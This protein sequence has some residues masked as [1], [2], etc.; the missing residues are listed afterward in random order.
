[1]VD[2]DEKTHEH[3]KVSILL[4]EVSSRLTCERTNYLLCGALFKIGGWAVEESGCKKD[5]GYEVKRRNLQ[6]SYCTTSEYVTITILL[7]LRPN[8]L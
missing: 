6:W 2:W 5:V 1:M 7:T 4:V 8:F 3:E